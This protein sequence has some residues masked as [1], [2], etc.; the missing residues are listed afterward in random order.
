MGNSGPQLED[1]LALFDI[2]RAMVRHRIIP[3]DE[4]PEPYHRLLVHPQ[5]M[6][7]TVEDYYGGPVA[8]RVLQRRRD[9]DTYARKIV[10]DM[11]G[12]L[13]L[14]GIVRIHLNHCDEAVRQA[15]LKEQT[16]LGRILIEHNVL[17]RIEP[18][19]YLVFDR[20]LT[21]SQ[22]MKLDDET[23]GRLGII[24]CDHQPA[25]ELLEIL[26]PIPLKTASG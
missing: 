21:F 4:V 1:L 24:Y 20:G 26:A 16:P 2:P 11:H 18:T 3:S 14:F 22:G 17:R 9:R 6:T 23:F 12:N 10:L 25:I 19:A 5:H 8:V 13:V 7:V 15:I